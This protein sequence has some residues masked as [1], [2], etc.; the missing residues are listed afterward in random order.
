MRPRSRTCVRARFDRGQIPI[1]VLVARH[2]RHDDPNAGKRLKQAFKFSDTYSGRGLGSTLFSLPFFLFLFSSLFLFPSPR[3]VTVWRH[4]KIRKGI[5]GGRLPSLHDLTRDPSL[6]LSLYFLS[7]LG[8]DVM[9]W[10]IVRSISMR[11]CKEANIRAADTPSNVHTLNLTWW[12]MY[13]IFSFSLEMLPSISPNAKLLYI[14]CRN[15]D[16]TRLLSKILV[17]LSQP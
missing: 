8:Q 3:R 2:Q 13:F 7:N 1:R 4:G 12:Y 6:S 5:L 17:Y 14:G 9:I 10:E 16:E 11:S 15:A